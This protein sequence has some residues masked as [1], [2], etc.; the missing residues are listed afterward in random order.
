MT[1]H[2]PGLPEALAARYRLEERL[3]SGGNAEVWRATDTVLDRSVAIKLLHRHLVTDPTTR[4]RLAQEARAAASLSHPGIV[5]VYDVAIDDERGAVVLELVDG[6][7]V[8]DRLETEG[9]LPPREAARVAAEVAEA[10]AHAHSHG[11]V[12]RDVKAANVLLGTDGSA[13]LVDFGIARVLDDE[14]ARLTTGG[15]ITGTLVYLAPEQ[16]QGDP[17]GPPAD[18][19]AA[20]L[21]LAE[22]LTGHPLYQVSTPVALV[23]AQRA[24]PLDIGGAPEGLTAIIRRGLDPDPAAR[25]PSASAL[26]EDLR[27]WL[28]GASSPVAGPAPATAAAEA[29]TE[30]ALPVPPPSAVPPS[31]APPSPPP[32]AAATPRRSGPR[33]WA[34]AAV[35]LLG[36]LAV[37]VAVVALIGGPDSDRG[38]PGG[39]TSPS[40]TSSAT[41]SA[42]P[43]PTPSPTPIPMTVA[44]AVSAFVDLVDQGQADS[45]ITSD[46][47][48]RLRELA[49]DVQRAAGEPGQGQANR[50]LR[51]LRRAINQ[52][53]ADGQIASDSLEA[54]LQAA[55]DEIERAVQRQ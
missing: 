17:G 22:M 5:A 51:D 19:Y 23:E 35:I 3:A 2:D 34:V 7:S 11:V 10:L 36:V 8:A 40:P 45:L 12:H 27:G 21:L 54:D 37:L 29:P 13:R 18:I 52:L 14:A 16:L 33:P 50:A 30:P 46:A 42:P 32:P 20:C 49:D 48:D 44:E 1:E 28:A 38:S 55:V 9:P 24:P 31:P 4:A 47:A 25:Q 43:S 53:A 6:P 15:T 39:T 26:A 41:A